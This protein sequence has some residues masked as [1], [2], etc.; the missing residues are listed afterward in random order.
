MAVEREISINIASDGREW[1][2]DFYVL[3]L[4]FQQLMRL[5]YTNEVETQRPARYFSFFSR[6]LW[7]VIRPWKHITS[8]LYSKVCGT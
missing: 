8:H 7:L 2:K 4:I 1:T 5:P 6:C 3:R